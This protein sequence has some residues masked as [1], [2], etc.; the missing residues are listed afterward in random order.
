[1]TKYFTLANSNNSLSKRFRVVADGFVDNLEKKQDVKTT[2]DGNLD[3][4]V[5]SIFRV[6]QF[7]VRVRYE[8]EV[9]DYSGSD[10]GTYEDLKRFFRYNNP[11]GTPSN[12]LTLVDHYGDT[13][14]VIFSENFQ[15]KPFA[16]TLIGTEA[17]YFVNVTFLCIAAETEDGGSGS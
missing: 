17:W 13:Y 7:V 16:T 8:E 3:V 1:M 9:D 2:I 5:G 15:G 6:W 14:N 11:G 10:W 12:I 4:S